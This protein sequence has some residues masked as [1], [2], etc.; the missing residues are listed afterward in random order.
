MTE[1][2]ATNTSDTPEPESCDAT[3][4]NESDTVELLIARLETERDDAIALRQ[5]A[6]ADYANFQR[7]SIENEARA[8]HFG[9]A[10]LAR[11]LMPVLDHFDLTVS[12][13]LSKLT[14]EQI[15]KSVDMTRT[16]MQRALES[17]G[18]TKIDPAVGSEFNP[19]QHEAVTQMLVEG[20]AAGT[21]AMLF[22]CGWCLGDSVLRPAKVAVTPTE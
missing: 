20:A 8:R 13:D 15:A 19:M 10:S 2:D 11:A 4:V 18:L 14:V 21:V 6:L 17:N 16:Q 9:I 5:R 3:A 7:R 22:Q 1:T 12:Q